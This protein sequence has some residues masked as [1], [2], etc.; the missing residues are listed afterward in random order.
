MCIFILN[1]TVVCAA[2]FKLGLGQQNDDDWRSDCSAKVPLPSVGEW[3]GIWARRNK[4]HK[5][6]LEELQV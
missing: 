5:Y 2:A 1:C 6:K 4:I 3:M